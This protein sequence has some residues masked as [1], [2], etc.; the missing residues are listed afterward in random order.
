MEQNGRGN[1]NRTEAV[2]KRRPV[3]APKA[4]GRAARIAACGWVA[5]AAL[6]LCSYE[7]EAPAAPAV[8]GS[9][10][11]LHVTLRLDRGEDR[12]Q[13]FGSLFEI[14]DG[15]GRA[16]AGAGFMGAYNTNVR[17]E[18]SNL[19]FFVAPDDDD[20][21]NLKRLPRMNDHT[22]LMLRGGGGGREIFGRSWSGDDTWRWQPEA[23]AWAPAQDVVIFP[24]MRLGPGLLEFGRRLVRHDGSPVLDVSNGQQIREMLSHYYAGGRLY[25]LEVT[26]EGT[27][28]GRSLVSCPWRP[29]DEAIERSSCEQLELLAG[30]ILYAWGQL[31]DVV[32]A[33]TSYGGIFTFDRSRWQTVRAADPDVSFQIYSMLNYHDD[34]LMGHYPTGELFRFDGFSLRLERGWPGVMDGVPSEKREAQTLAIYRGNLFVGVWPWGELWRYSPRYAPSRQ[35]WRLAA[36]LF[37]EPEPSYL[38]NPWLVESVDAGIEHNLWGQ[39][40]TSLIPW[41]GS[42]YASTSGKKPEPT[43]TRPD[44]LS[45]ELWREYGRVWR[46][47]LPGEVTAD[48]PWTGGPVLLDFVIDRSSMRIMLDGRLVAS[49]PLPASWAGSLDAREIAWGEGIW[50]TSAG[51]IT[52]NQVLYPPAGPVGP[53]H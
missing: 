51:R 29:G 12:G 20:A 34:L 10:S 42:L 49:G 9:F 44:F 30:D 43:D 48:V 13:N 37:R 53:D 47:D 38:E 22:G 36:R 28:A 27:T 32:V 24:R 33:T 52:E 39:R 8:Q 15:A 40:I 26:T 5:C 46:V 31:D 50:G 16:I 17:G 35:G 21:V 3:R 14:R 45:E 11:G 7:T 2:N 19:Q 4:D 1:R 25:F 41:R 6:V 18:R 23:N